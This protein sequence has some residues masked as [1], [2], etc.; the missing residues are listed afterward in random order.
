MQI[1]AR[2]IVHAKPLDRES[3]ESEEHSFSSLQDSLALV[4]PRVSLD[5]RVAAL[6]LLAMTTQKHGE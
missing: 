5:R 2:K 1:L 3:E 4:F 6:P